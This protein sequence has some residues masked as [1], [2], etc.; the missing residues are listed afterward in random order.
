MP[1]NVGSLSFRKSPS[2]LTLKGTR[3]LRAPASVSSQMRA[4]RPSLVDELYCKAQTHVGAD[5]DPITC[6]LGDCAEV[7]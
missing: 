6:V 7:T 2:R 5:S 4:P 1:L 3:A